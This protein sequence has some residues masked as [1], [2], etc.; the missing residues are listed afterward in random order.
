MVQIP[1]AGAATV[2][3]G[4]RNATITG[5]T[6]VTGI[7]V[8]LNATDANHER[9]QR[10]HRRQQL[11]VSALLQTTG[12]VRFAPALLA[13]AAFII[14]LGMVTVGYRLFR[15]SVF[16]ITFATGGLAAARAIEGVFRN[17]SYLAAASWISFVGA[18]L[19][20]AC[21]AASL[22]YVGIF[23]VGGAAGVLLA[24]TLNAGVGQE[25]YPSNPDA[26]L[27]ALAII[28]GVAG[29]MTA[30]KSRNAPWL[31]AVPGAW[32]GYIAALI[33]LTAVGA[34]V[35]RKLTA[36]DCYYDARN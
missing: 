14:G 27:L 25:I 10:Q 5:N 34:V 2:A 7:T 6:G 35:Q 23:V 20:V 29:G 28:L 19:L 15:A 9:E 33:A 26:V 22:Y 4:N 24:V 3:S 30:S 32:W 31:A 13:V 21:I 8:D 36:R 11:T 17:E 16:A 1:L 12:D 18:G